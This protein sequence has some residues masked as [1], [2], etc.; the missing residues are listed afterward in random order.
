[1]KEKVLFW[2]RWLLPLALAVAG[3]FLYGSTP[4]NFLGLI[5]L[6]LAGLVSAYYG[7]SLL[8][9]RALMAGKIL[10]SILTGLVCLGLLV[11]TVT[12]VYTARD[13]RGQAGEFCPYIVVL[14]AKVNGTAPS[15]I[16]QQ[17]IDAAFAYLT[18]HPDAVAVLSGGQGSD[19]GISEAQC[20]FEGLTEMGIAADRLWL[21]ETST[22]TWENIR[23][24]LAL[25]E[26][27]SGSRPEALGLVT[28]EFH[29]LRAGLFAKECGVETLGIPAKTDNFLH[30]C[31]YFLREIAGV[32]HYFI[33]GG[34][35]D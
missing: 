26:E 18:E 17:R 22:S 4:T 10:Y 2:G 28:S 5:C 16:L 32:W 21:E 9:R 25:I 31:N 20:M 24:S 35:Y 6:A 33:L 19:E 14:G 15:Q 30:F 3:I 29:L 8:S 11:V 12:G 13:A 23:L 34:F 7:I 1:M 27:K